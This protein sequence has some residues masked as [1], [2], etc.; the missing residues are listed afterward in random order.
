MGRCHY[1]QTETTPLL[2]S[3][4][5]TLAS[6][7]KS[8]M[9][10]ST[11]AAATFLA[12]RPPISLVLTG[13]EE[14]AALRFKGRPATAT[15]TSDWKTLSVVGEP[16]ELN[17]DGSWWKIIIGLAEDGAADAGEPVDWE[18]QVVEDSSG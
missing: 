4:L 3:I 2:S 13:S 12:P 1:K 18:V 11:A 8:S 14:T 6:P 15:A 7:I 16:E 9:R 10:G 5:T 17:G